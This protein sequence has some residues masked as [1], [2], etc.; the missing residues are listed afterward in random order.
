MHVIDQSLPLRARPDRETARSAPLRQVPPPPFQ[1]GGP[2]SV[3]DHRDD[4]SL[5]GGL[6]VMLSVALPFWV[7][8]IT[9][10]LSLLW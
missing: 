10:L 8:M 2:L 3:R 9:L 7:V 4:G 6:M 5:L 1:R